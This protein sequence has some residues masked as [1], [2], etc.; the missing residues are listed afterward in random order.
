[1]QKLSL[2]FDREILVN[3]LINNWGDSLTVQWLGLCV[4]TART[5][6]RSLGRELRS[7]K[8]VWFSQIN[9]QLIIPT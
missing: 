5:R 9:N 8:A 6:V 4:S 7:H 1:M 2:S 3:V